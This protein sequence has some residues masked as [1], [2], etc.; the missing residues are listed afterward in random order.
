MKSEKIEAILQYIQR[1]KVLGN[2]SKN[3]HLGTLELLE[4]RC[5][6]LE[7]PLDAICL[8]FE[9]GLTK[10]YHAAKREAKKEALGHGA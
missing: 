7:T 5:M 8:A 10:G 2:I 1:G 6:A 3:Y 4:L 9:Y